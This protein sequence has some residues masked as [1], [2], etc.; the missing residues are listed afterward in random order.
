MSTKNSIYTQGLQHAEKMIRYDDPAMCGDDE[1]EN[2]AFRE[3][4]QIRL[5][6]ALK[7]NRLG[8]KLTSAVA[9]GRLTLQ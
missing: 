5:A 2:D 3:G 6:S 8:P 9:S 1:W 4:L 7:D